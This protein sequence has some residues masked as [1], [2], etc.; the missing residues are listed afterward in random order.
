MAVQAA[1]NDDSEYICLPQL[2][3]GVE[4]SLT[5]AVCMDVCAEWLGTKL[6]WVLAGAE[7]SAGSVL[8]QGWGL[9]VRRT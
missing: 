8:V 9:G 2:S 3:F 1:A 5:P 6:S 4:V 7:I